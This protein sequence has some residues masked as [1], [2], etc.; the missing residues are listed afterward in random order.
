LE[1][2]QKQQVIIILFPDFNLKSQWFFQLRTI[3]KQTR[4]NKVYKNKGLVVS[5][6]ILSEVEGSHGLYFLPL[7]AK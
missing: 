3:L 5:E 6:L 1:G 4:K 7:G 2:K